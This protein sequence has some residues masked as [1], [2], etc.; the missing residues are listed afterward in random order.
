MLLLQ[1]VTAYP[2][3]GGFYYSAYPN[4]ATTSLTVERI[5]EESD[6]LATEASNINLALQDFTVELTTELGKKVAGKKSNGKKTELNTQSLRK[7]IYILNIYTGSEK[8]SQR[9]V[10][11]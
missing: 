6:T 10:I 4:P 9:I 1:A 3:C 2:G 7:G 11:E 5:E 8:L